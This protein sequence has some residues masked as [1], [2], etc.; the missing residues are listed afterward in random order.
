VGATDPSDVLQ[1]LQ[2]SGFPRDASMQALLQEFI[3][4]PPSLVAQGVDERTFYN[5]IAQYE[6]QLNG[7]VV[8][9]VGFV[10]AL[11][12]RFITPLD[13]PRSV[14]LVEPRSSR[15]IERS[16]RQGIG[17]VRKQKWSDFKLEAD[18]G[19]WPSFVAGKY[20]IV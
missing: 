15:C 7:F 20:I 18:F 8:D 13:E 3:P 2:F 17:N 11:E 10:K 1:R 4:E 14:V 5:S 19:R 6:P 12:D 9:S 16:Y